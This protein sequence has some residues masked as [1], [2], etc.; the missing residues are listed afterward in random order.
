MHHFQRTTEFQL[1]FVQW[2]KKLIRTP[3]YLWDRP[4]TT[5]GM[6]WIEKF[7]NFFLSIIDSF[8]EQTFKGLH[9]R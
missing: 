9:M 7:T 2:R 4:G 6:A 1:Y 8:I 5:I 3:N